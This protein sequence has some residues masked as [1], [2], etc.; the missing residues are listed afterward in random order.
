MQ[1]QLPNYMTRTQLSH[2]L[3]AATV[4]SKIMTGDDLLTKNKSNVTYEF[5]FKTL[6][7]IEGIPYQFLESADRRIISS[8]GQDFGRKYSQKILSQLPILFLMPCRPKFMPGYD[9]SQQKIALE[10]LFEGVS[11]RLDNFLELKTGG[12]YYSVQFAYAEYYLY[13]N[14]MIQSVAGYMGLGDESVNLT[15]K[16]EADR[17][18]LIRYDWY[19]MPQFN[20]K[21]FA[22]AESV[23]FFVDSLNTIDTSFGN[24]TR[25]STIAGTINNYSDMANEVRFLLGDEESVVAT[26]YDQVTAATSGLGDITSGMVNGLGGSLISSLTKGGPE[27]ILQGGRLIFPDI[28]SDSDHSESYSF[29]LKLRSPDH[30]SL[31]IFLNILVPYCKILAMTM[32]Q[33]IAGNQSSYKSPFL[34]KAYCKGLFSIDMGIIDSLQVTKGAECMWNDDGLPTQIDINFSIK[35]LYSSLAMSAYDGDLKQKFNNLI[36]STAYMDFLANMAGCNIMKE[37]YSLSGKMDVAMYS[38]SNRINIRQ[39]LSRL[40]NKFS[41]DISNTIGRT[42]GFVR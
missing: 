11:D 13:L 26:L 32:P 3:T 5:P 8:S 36:S 10:S 14:K 12:M 7:S 1:S 23:A 2:D 25:P 24:D 16:G 17:I 18:P 20:D 41:N 6:N 30:D 31:S 28:W 34:V 38:I 40:Y 35:N 37:N 21:V 9:E 33:T 42:L 39:N 15:G 29:T 4:K 22:S 27:S 19:N